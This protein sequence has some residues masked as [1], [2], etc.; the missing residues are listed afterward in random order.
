MLCPLAFTTFS[1]L[2]ASIAAASVGVSQSIPGKVGLRL[3]K[4]FG[5]D[6][7]EATKG[8]NPASANVVTEYM[9]L[10]M[11]ISFRI[12]ASSRR[13]CLERFAQ[14]TCQI[15]S[16]RIVILTKDDHRSLAFRQNRPEPRDEHDRL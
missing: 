10:R 13:S 2:H 9:R 12:E 14:H 3:S 5:L 16:S 4:S 11:G 1:T 6:W 15:P 7:A 8:A